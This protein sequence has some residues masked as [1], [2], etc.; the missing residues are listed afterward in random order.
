VESKKTFSVK[1]IIIAIIGFHVVTTGI[2]T[3]TG[4][5][6]KYH[7]LLDITCHFRCQY[8][9]IQLGCL[10]ISVMY[11]NRILIVFTVFLL[12]INAAQIFPIYLDPGNRVTETNQTESSDDLTS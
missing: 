4:F 2:L 1:R 8:F 10:L 5:L 11:K 7:W 6:G 3:I 12:V 9:C